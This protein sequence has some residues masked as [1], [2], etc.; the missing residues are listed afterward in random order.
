MTLYS[1]LV[2]GKLCTLARLMC[3]ESSFTIFELRVTDMTGGEVAT[4]RARLVAKVAAAMADRSPEG[5]AQ[6]LLEAVPLAELMIT[7]LSLGKGLRP[8]SNFHA[9][10]SCNK[11]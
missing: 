8:C 11:A 7:C 5:V 2:L 3:E 1:K 10:C 9:T 4:A 6:D